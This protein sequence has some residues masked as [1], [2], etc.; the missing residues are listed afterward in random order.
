MEA[1]IKTCKKFDCVE[2]KRQSQIKLMQEY[3]KRK[4]EFISYM[5]FIKAKVREDKWSQQIW[6]RI[7]GK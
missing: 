3:E 7:G 1:M 5:E 6:N 2:F 4:D